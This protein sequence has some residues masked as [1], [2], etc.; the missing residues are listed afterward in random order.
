MPTVRIG[1]GGPFGRNV[2]LAARVRRHLRD[3]GQDT[4][5]VTAGGICSPWQ[6]EEILRRGEADVVASARQTLADP[7]WFLK[8]RHGHGEEVRRCLFTNYCEALDQAHKEVTCQRWDRTFSD[9]EDPVAVPLAADGRRRL[10]PPAWNL[11]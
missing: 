7:D 3:A 9:D 2:A 8:I 4:P 10:V 6:A 1:E 5:V 11:P